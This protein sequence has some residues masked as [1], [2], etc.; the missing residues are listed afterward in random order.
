[1][2][3]AQLIHGDPGA[4]PNDA[5]TMPQTINQPKKKSVPL[6]QQCVGYE[7]KFAKGHTTRKNGECAIKCCRNCC[8]QLKPIDIRCSKHNAMPK[9][10]QQNRV[11]G[12]S[13][14]SRNA[15]QRQRIQS[16][17]IKNDTQGDAEPVLTQGPP[18]SLSADVYQASHVFSSPLS[19]AQINRFRQTTL[20][21]QAEE[22]DDKD[23]ASVAS[24]TATFVVWAGMDDN[25]LGCETWRVYAPRWPTLKLNQSTTL[26]EQV[27]LK[28]GDTWE[29]VTFKVWDS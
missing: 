20:Q 7:G 28:L 1:M 2:Q 26:M 13:N 11:G 5:Q 12:N 10:K 4:N 6:I 21:K 16:P 18:Q 25:P 22:R 24:K 17:S 19:A 14:V 3:V 9:T 8:E 23:H 15:T 29:W 27:R